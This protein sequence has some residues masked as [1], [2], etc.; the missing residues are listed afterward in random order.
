MLLELVYFKEYLV[1]EKIGKDQISGKEKIFQKILFEC[2]ISPE[3]YLLRIFFVKYT[4]QQ[5]PTIARNN[6]THNISVSESKTKYY[7]KIPYPQF[8]D[9]IGSK[10]MFHFIGGNW[11]D[12]NKTSQIVWGEV[13]L[14]Q[15]VT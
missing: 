6:D 15:S 8:S 2:W 7:K 5:I 1:L 13:A 9:V 14:V 12:K 10:Q 4:F 11:L 3:M